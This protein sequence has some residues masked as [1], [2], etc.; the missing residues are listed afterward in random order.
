MVS[1]LRRHNFKLQFL[2]RQQQKMSVT[3][4]VTMS[5]IYQRVNYLKINKIY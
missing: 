5:V 2:H 3:M 1:H 4:S